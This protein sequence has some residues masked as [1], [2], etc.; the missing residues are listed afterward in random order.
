MKKPEKEG[1]QP[2]ITGE[3]LSELA[4][5]L[6]KSGVP[7]SEIN[8]ILA[9]LA[10]DSLGKKPEDA[11]PGLIFQIVEASYGRPLTEVE[12]DGIRADVVQSLKETYKQLGLDESGQLKKQ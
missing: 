5:S 12:K 11:D 8:N 9:K 4:G 10:A 7:D 2:Y 6:K 3:S 1:R